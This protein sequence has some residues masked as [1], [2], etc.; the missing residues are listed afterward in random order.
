MPRR[1]S[2]IEREIWQK[3]ATFRKDQCGIS[4]R[5][6]SDSL[7][8]ENFVHHTVGTSW[9]WPCPTNALCGILTPWLRTHS[10]SGSQ[11]THLCEASKSSFAGW[12]VALLSYQ[13]YGVRSALHINAS[14]SVSMQWSTWSRATRG[15]LCF[16]SDGIR[17]EGYSSCH[18]YW[19][20]MLRQSVA[21][22]S[23]LGWLSRLDLRR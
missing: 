13:R 1:F 17:C 4:R 9:W 10:T 3:L 2:R 21:C 22:Q 8:T 6:C 20:T 19:R 23:K 12:P 16:N 5:S 18:T 7:S 15:L 11:R 14:R